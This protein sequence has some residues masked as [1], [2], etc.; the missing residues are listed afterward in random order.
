MKVL[1]VTQRVDRFPDRQEQRDALDERLGLWLSSSGFLV[2]PLPNVL[3]ATGM[4]QAWLERIEPSGII[5]SGGNDIG[6]GSLRDD[7]E[8]ALLEH[9]LNYRLPV[10]GICRGMQMI[11]VWSGIK[12]KPVDGHVGTRH[13]IRGTISGTVNS[14]HR[15]SWAECPSQYEVLARSEDGEIEA[16][17]HRDLPWE[18]WMWHPEREVEI[19]ELNKFRLKALFS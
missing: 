1:V 9:A 16:I 15:F 5:L 19:D 2:Y 7:S 10:L 18:G 11:G 3:V 4:L 14:F 17:R 6:D 12:L 8:K 13:A